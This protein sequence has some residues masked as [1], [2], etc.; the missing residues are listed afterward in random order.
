MSYLIVYAILLTGLLIA[1][2]YL[3]LRPNG[4]LERLLILKDERAETIQESTAKNREKISELAGI[5]HEL[6]AE[7]ES[8]RA[9][10]SN[11]LTS[12]ES[13]MGR[14]RRK[15]EKEELAQQ[16]TEAITQI[17]NHRG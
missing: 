7:L 12:L 3:F 9:M 11:R 6:S 15:Q 8:A 2:V 4:V 13:R 10:A 16:L 5:V 1:L 17:P 14:D